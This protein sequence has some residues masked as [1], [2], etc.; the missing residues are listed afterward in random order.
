VPSGLDGVTAVAAGGYQSMA[1]GD[2]NRPPD[3]TGVTAAPGSISRQMRDKLALVTLSGATDLDGDTLSYQIDGVTQDEYVRGVGDDTRPDAALTSAG[4]SSNQVFVRS[5]A[6]QLFNGRVY[7]IAY[8]V[9]DGN[10]G[11]CSG[12][13][14][15][16]GNTTAKVSVSRKNGTTAIDDGNARSWDSFTGAA[17]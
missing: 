9:S 3:C 17:M 12:T 15:R 11:S 4:T 10:G 6:N 8:N 2:I 1:S 13:A 14:G 16:N 7:R 5:E